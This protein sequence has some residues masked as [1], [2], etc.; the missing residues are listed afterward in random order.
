MQIP[1]DAFFSN[2]NGVFTLYS[3][4]FSVT[5][6]KSKQKKVKQTTFGYKYDHLRSLVAIFFFLACRFLDV[7]IY[8]GSDWLVP[9]LSV[10]H[11]RQFDWLTHA[12][13]LEK[14]NILQLFPQANHETQRTGSQRV[15]NSCWQ[16]MTSPHSK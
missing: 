6:K 11:E 3:V 12:L 15:Y 8:T 5:S 16:R 13:P 10:M 1:S 2:N 14:L 4:Y 7:S 9:V